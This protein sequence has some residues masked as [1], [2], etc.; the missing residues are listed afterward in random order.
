MIKSR[1]TWAL[2]LLRAALPTNADHIMRKMAISYTHPRGC[3]NTYR[4]TT[5]ANTMVRLTASMMAT[6]TLASSAR[7]WL[8]SDKPLKLAEANDRKWLGGEE[9]MLFLFLF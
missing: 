5:P 7:T 2:S 9:V 8:M 3:P 4:K 6:E 1:D